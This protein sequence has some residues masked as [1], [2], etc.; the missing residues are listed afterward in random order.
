MSVIP[1]VALKAYAAILFASDCSA[2][3]DE[4]AWGSKEAET[5]SPVE[6]GEPAISVKDPVLVQ[7]TA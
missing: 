5:P 6:R 2:Y 4:P 1:V 3:T 7:L